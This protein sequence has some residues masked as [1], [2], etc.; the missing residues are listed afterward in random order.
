[1]VAEYTLKD[2]NKPIGVSAYRL[3]DVLPGDF[4][5]YLPSREDLQNRI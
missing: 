4:A 3:G 5:K 1:M 2:V